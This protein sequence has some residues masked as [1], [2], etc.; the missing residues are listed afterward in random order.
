MKTKELQTINTEAFLNTIRHEI[1]QTPK[2]V[3]NKK[4]RK[5]KI[6][7]CWP[8]DFW[9]VTIFSTNPCGEKTWCS[10]STVIGYSMW[11]IV[12]KR[13]RLGWIS[14]EPNSRPAQRQKE[15][16]PQQQ[17]STETAERE[18]KG[19][20]R[21]EYRMTKTGN[22]HME[23]EITSIKQSVHM[24]IHEIKHMRKQEIQENIT[25]DSILNREIWRNLRQVKKKK[26]KKRKLR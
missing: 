10:T 21:K 20:N 23:L 26:R 15:R 12:T 13:I 16:R 17:T 19:M 8:A 4:V 3:S 5:E 24:Q 18:E 14:R 1:L 11:C 9:N 2:P 7:R 6:W 22:G 25:S